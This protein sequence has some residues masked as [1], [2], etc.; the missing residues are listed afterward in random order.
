MYDPPPMS[1]AGSSRAARRAA[2]EHRVGRQLESEDFESASTTI[3]REYGP[4]I[5][6]YLLCILRTNEAAGEV[7]AQ[8]NLD[9]W[10]GIKGFRCEGTAYAWY[11]KLAYHSAM[12]FLKNPYRVRGRRLESDELAAI[13]AQSKSSAKEWE[14]SAGGRIIERLREQLTPDEQTLLTLHIHEEFGHQEIAALMS[15]PAP[16]VRKR[17]VRLVKKLQQLAGKE[18]LLLEP[19]PEGSPGP[20]GTGV[21]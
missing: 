16:T 8:A 19:T 17:W 1:N 6:S 5:L 7:F 11:Y 21:K 13:E 9:L 20:R 15:L 18:G 10:T 14:N 12:R 3:V 4:E 2:T